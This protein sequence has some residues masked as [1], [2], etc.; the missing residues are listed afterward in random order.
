MNLYHYIFVEHPAGSISS[1]T[2]KI[3][4]VAALLLSAALPL[5]AQEGGRV[6]VTGIVTEAD[7]ARPL[8]SVTVKALGTKSGAVTSMAGRFLLRLPPGNYTLSFSMVGYRTEKRDIV[9][10][11]DTLRL[12]MVMEEAA[13]QY[14][15]VVVSAEDPG[16]KLMRRVIA[17]KMEQRDS[18]ATY[19]YMLYTKFVASTDTLTAGR[20][21][22]AADTTIVSIFESYSRGYFRKPE[23][24]F[25]EIIQRRQSA[26]IPPQSNFVAFG[27]NLNAYDDEVSV[28][29]EQISTP[30]HPDALDYYDFILERTIETGDSTRVSRVAVTPKGNGRK[31]F[32]GYVNIDADRLVPI[33]VELRPNR[34]VRLPFDARLEYE[35]QFDEVDGR[36]V[37]PTGLRIY[38]TLKAEL[39]W[40][41]APRLDVTIET[42]AYDYATNIP[43]DDDLFQRRRVEASPQAEEFDSTYW[44]DK[45]VLPLRPEEEEAYEA[46]LQARDNP[47]SV[48]GTGIFGQFFTG[49]TREL[50]KLNRPPFTGAEDIFRYNRVHGPYAGL[51]LRGDILTWLEATVLGGYGFTDRRGYGDLTLRGYLDSNRRFSF[52]GNIYRRLQRR[53]NPYRVNTGAIT[54]LSLISKSDYGDYYYADGFELAAEATF[55]QLRFIRRET[56]ARPTGIRVFFRN[57]EERT[58]IR[59][60]NFA[61]LGWNKTFRENP[62][63]IDG[64]MR[65]T[66]LE[67]N[68]EYSPY[69]RLSNFGFRLTGEFANPD[70]LG[71]DFN[72]EQYT[73]ALTIRTPTLPLWRLDVRASGGFSRG[74]IPPQRFFSLESSF[75]STAAEGVFRGMRVKEFYGDRFA[76]LSLEHSFGEIIPGVL[77]IPNIAAFGIEFIAMANVGWTGFSNEARFAQIN[78][79]SFILPSTDVTGDRLYYEAGIALNRIL[80]FFRIDLA[81]R[82]S[83]VE[84]PKF[85][86]TIGG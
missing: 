12:D 43:L 58:A 34:A 31:L 29:G 85:I 2:M 25:N 71:G 79:E 15:G 86:F 13:F 7:S 62:P 75:S 74:A 23:S 1:D 14:P 20:T 81:A 42:V 63:I 68:W 84:K 26:N 57:E 56:Y 22:R 47:D 78:G 27:T 8:K 80:L 6:V 35:Q 53:D 32:S 52:Q 59:T 18:L 48:Q 61:L 30:F 73:A 21:D 77:R 76:A 46:I 4:L 67:F 16:V 3:I 72:F 24:Y 49:I 39:F 44:F 38:G 55:G 65:S 82:F 17:R 51:G 45:A 28:L 5:P 9:A 69:R 10:A 19:S 83:Q 64:T 36:F 33:S 66:G 54:I 41:I 70:L 50:G 40:V 11:G 37:L 60:T